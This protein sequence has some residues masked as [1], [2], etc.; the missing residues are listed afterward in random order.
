MEVFDISTKVKGVEKSTPLRLLPVVVF[1]YTSTQEVGYE[2][3]T[4]N[5]RR[6]FL[7]D[8]FLQKNIHQ[9]VFW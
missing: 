6:I 2:D 5:S 1:S 8:C 3:V 4:Y 9:L 7:G